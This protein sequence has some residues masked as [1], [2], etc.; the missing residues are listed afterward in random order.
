ML[1][2]DH[3]SSSVLWIE[4]QKNNNWHAVLAVAKSRVSLQVQ[5]L[6]LVIGVFTFLVGTVG[7][8]IT[9]GRLSSSR[10]LR[11]QATVPD[12]TVEV[13]IRPPTS[14]PQI[15]QPFEIPLSIN[16]Q[17]MQVD[18]VQLAIQL[19]AS[20][21]DLSVR[22][23]STLPLQIVYQDIEQLVNQKVF[24]LIVIHSQIGQPFSTTS[25]QQFLTLTAK[26]TQAGAFVI[27]AD[28]ARSLVTR[29]RSDP[30]QDVLKPIVSLNLSVGGGTQAT[31][32]PTPTQRVGETPIPTPPCTTFL[33]PDKTQVS[34]LS[35]QGL[36]VSW[37]DTNPN[38]YHQAEEAGFKIYRI[39]NDPIY[40]QTGTPSNP[41]IV[42]LP[43]H[44]GNGLMSFLYTDESVKFG[45]VPG[46]FYR[47]LIYTWKEPEPGRPIGCYKQSAIGTTCP[48]TIA[49]T[50][51]PTRTPTPTSGLAPTRTPTPT[52]S[53]Q[54]STPK[55]QFTAQLQGLTIAEIPMKSTLELETVQFMDD[56]AD[57]V[58][59]TYRYD[60][61][62][63]SSDYGLLKPLLG[64][65]ELGSIPTKTTYTVFLKTSWSLRRN[66]G[67]ITLGEGYNE[68]PPTFDRRLLLVGDF[69]TLPQQEF[70]VLNILDVADML[71]VYSKLVTPVD[72]QISKYDV[73]FD[74]KIDILDIA[75]VL[76]NYTQLEIRGD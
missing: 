20:F 30:P 56:R 72:P 12:G 58:P 1:L 4:M 37:N 10:D 70:N 68:L 27:S 57:I 6:L 31:N 64:P 59:T 14:T 25:L 49:S 71:K 26:P 75:L 65:V 7:V 50:P 33:R 47:F 51:T 36:L 41:P 3:H 62:L 22:I 35:N 45:Y 53:F 39:D 61:E 8:L 5:R 52:A 21:T 54:T 13:A 74:Q 73:N 19:P 69:V 38:P 11:Q 63:R 18:G 48:T 76:S 28:P 66:I 40:D 44:K 67:Q 42:T 9:L 34:C 15:N 46:K 32:T 17:G 23:N 2:F 43:Q 29:H 24:K 16:T 60:V 55:L